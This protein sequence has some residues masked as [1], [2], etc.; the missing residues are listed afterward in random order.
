MGNEPILITGASGVLGRSMVRAFT[1]ANFPVRR[2]V[3]RPPETPGTETVHFDYTKAET[4][5]PALAGAHGLLLMAP[6]LDPGAP[7]KLKPVIEL[8]KQAGISRIAFISAFG[9]NFNEQAP[10]RIVERQVMDSGIPF[11]ILR[12]NFFMENFSEGFLSGTIKGQN[13]I[14]LAAGDGKTSFISA[15]DIAGVAV[16]FFSDFAL[17]REIDL[18]GPEALDHAEVAGMIGEVSGRAISY[19]AL[20]EDQMVAGVRSAGV[21]EPAIGYMKALYDVVRAGHAAGVTG[22]VELVLGRPPISFRK[23]AEQNASSWM[24]ANAYSGEHK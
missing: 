9:V 19:H 14:F 20:T 16:K 23:F 13:G 21:P 18:T 8:A 22:D 24:T 10:L 4:F 2:G 11:A 15:E 3:R 6:P 17:K 7:A 12:P 1:K 5:G